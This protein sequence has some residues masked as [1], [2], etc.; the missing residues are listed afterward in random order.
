MNLSFSSPSALQGLARVGGKNFSKKLLTSAERRVSCSR[1]LKLD[2]GSPNVFGT[3]R[4][5]GFCPLEKKF[6]G[7]RARCS[8]KIELCD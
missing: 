1:F 7:V 6:M 8:L 2:I 5:R 3:S 4:R